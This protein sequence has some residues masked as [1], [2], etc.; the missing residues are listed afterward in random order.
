MKFLHLSDLHL[1]KSVHG[2]SMI[3]EQE[4]ILKVILSVADE[5]KPDVVLI[6]GD[7]FDHY[8][9][10]KEALRLFD[11]FLVGLARRGIKTFVISGNHDSAQRLA[12][13]ARLVDKSG[14]FIAP[15][16]GGKIEKHVLEDEYGVLNIYLLPFI[17]PLHVRR[18]H[19]EEKI[20]TWTEALKIALE[21]IEL[22]EA[23]R[24][25]LVAHQFVT[26]AKTCASEEISIGGADNV[27]ASVFDAFDYVALGHLH[28]PQSVTRATLRYCGSPLKYSF[29]EASHKK[30]VTMIEMAEKGVIKID[31]IP[32]KAKR[33]LVDIRGEFLEVT[34]P[35]FFENLNLD[36]YYRVTLTDE[37]EAPDALN[38]L[39][40]VYPN[41]MCLQYDNTR[42][43]TQSE[44]AG[45][46]DAGA[47]SPLELFSMLYEEQNGLPLAEAQRLF[48]TDLIAQ[49]WEEE[50]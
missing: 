40:M 8:N 5:E 27:A 10:L 49:V 36:H 7:V 32:L 47:H 16:Y 14:V 1:G 42:T 46:K 45:L 43:R 2:F 11:D 15:P 44:V 39:R 4:Y 13:G 9:A 29:S 3:E 18:Y 34:A 22:D 12:F 19:E 50:K 23:Q 48:L 33:D 21:S 28:G 25:V 6:A 20:E 41:L 17:K 26:G 31:E 37:E 38:R 24:N 35:G 30:S